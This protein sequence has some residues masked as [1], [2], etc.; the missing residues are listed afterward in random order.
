MDTFDL[1]PGHKNGG[2]FKEISTAV[3]GIKISEHL[4]RVTRHLDK[5]ALV[6]SMTS[7]EGDHREAA[8]Y[9]HAGYTQ[10]GPVQYRRWGPWWPRR[11]A[12]T[13]PTCPRS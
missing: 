11:P 8:Y 10:R 5:L 7:K 3:P 12:R 9:V 1:K 13:R 4:P 6:R 2:P